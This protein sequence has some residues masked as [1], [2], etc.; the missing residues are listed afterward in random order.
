MMVNIISSS[1]QGLGMHPSRGWRQ[2]L[3]WGTAKFIDSSPPQ[4]SVCQQGCDEASVIHWKLKPW[5]SVMEMVFSVPVPVVCT[6][7]QPCTA[8]VNPTHVAF[9]SS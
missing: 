1:W 8:G 3:A 5:G 4:D 7:A 6:F 2:S 9:R